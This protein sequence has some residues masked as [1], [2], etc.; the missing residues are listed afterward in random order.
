MNKVKQLAILQAQ[1]DAVRHELRHI[2]PSLDAESRGYAMLADHAMGTAM[3]A[4]EEAIKVER[5]EPVASA[6]SGMTGVGLLGA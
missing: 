6:D 2:S 5:L 4:M 3:L 1:A